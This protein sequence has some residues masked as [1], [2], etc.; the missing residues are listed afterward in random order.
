MAFFWVG[1]SRRFGL[2]RLGKMCLDY[3]DKSV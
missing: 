3:D 2:L 1:E